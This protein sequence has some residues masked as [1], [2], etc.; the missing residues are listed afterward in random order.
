MEKQIYSQGK[1]KLIV[2]GLLISGIIINGIISTMFT[3]SGVNETQ[4]RLGY[5]ITIGSLLMGAG[6]GLA[7]SRIFKVQGIDN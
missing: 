4:M 3:L 7:C 1:Y 5:A 6:I 2:W